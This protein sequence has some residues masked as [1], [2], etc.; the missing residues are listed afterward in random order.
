VSVL[1]QYGNTVASSY[2]PG[3]NCFGRTANFCGKFS[4]GNG[5]PHAIGLPQKALPL[6]SRRDSE[7]YVVE[8]AKAHQAQ[9]L[10]CTAFR[11]RDAIALE[12]YNGGFTGN[13]KAYGM[14]CSVKRPVKVFALDHLFTS[15]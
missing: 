3:S 5:R 15:G 7:E 6:L 11:E 13:P 1:A 9:L 4:R 12:G 8:G 10:N 2:A 14:T